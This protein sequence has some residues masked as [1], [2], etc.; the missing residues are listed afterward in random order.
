MNRNLE[1]AKFD[2]EKVDSLMYAIEN[3]Y[4]SIDTLPEE[5]EKADRAV[6][7]FYALW[8]A[9][10]AVEDDIDRL[11]GD[12]VVVDAIYAVNDVIR[13]KCSLTKED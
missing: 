1:K 9:I 7:A 3:T 12:D 10:R 8:D 6:N 13:I 4:L 2:I 11:Q 5:R